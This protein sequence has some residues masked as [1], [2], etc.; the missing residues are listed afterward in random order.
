MILVLFGPQ[1]FGPPKLFNRIQNVRE[2]A[3]IQPEPNA[4]LVFGEALDF[5]NLVSMT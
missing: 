5:T 4:K 3:G 1:L 2:L